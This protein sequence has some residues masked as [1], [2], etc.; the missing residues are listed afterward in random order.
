MSHL[1]SPIQIGRMQLSHRLAMSPLTRA[2]AQADGTPGE[3]AAEYYAQRASLGLLISEGTQPSAD[4]Q[5]FPNSPGIHTDR[6]VSG[7][8][9]ISEAVHARGGHLFIQLMHAGRMTH[10]DNTPHGRQGVAPSAIAPRA[11]IYTKAGIQD[12]PAPRALSTQEIHATVNDFRRAAAL[13]VAA[14]AD[15]VEIHAA[16]GYLIQQFFSPNANQRDDDYGGRIENRIRLALEVAD[17]VTA[18]I[19]ADRTGVRISPGSTLGGIDEGPDYPELYRELAQEL[20]KRNLAYLHIAHNGNEDLLADLRA[21]WNGPLLVNRVNR[22]LAQIAR[23]ID[24]GLADMAPIGQWALAN[25]DLV[26]R[27]QGGHALNQPDPSTF[28]GEGA[29]GYT[30]YPLLDLVGNKA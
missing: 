7:W 21:L 12:V 29:Q 6:H 20:N 28:Y 2:R 19:G 23:D 11:S 5:G 22:P 25:P 9:E 27:L 4:G 14:D 13:A 16:N 24:A 8:R 17:A 26:E 1:W 30:D 18:E 3:L 15:G 10:P